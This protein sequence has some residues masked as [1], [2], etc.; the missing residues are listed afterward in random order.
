MPGIYDVCDS[1]AFQGCGDEVGWLQYLFGICKGMFVASKVP[2]IFRKWKTHFVF[3]VGFIF[4][5]HLYTKLAFNWELDLAPTGKRAGALNPFL[6]RNEAPRARRRIGCWF[7]TAVLIRLP[8]FPVWVTPFLPPF[9]HR[10]QVIWWLQAYLY[11]PIIFWLLRVTLKQL[12]E[13]VPRAECVC[14]SILG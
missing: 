10:S 11:S 9:V 5:A 12:W 2:R 6:K 7:L 13:F 14:L 4:F 3:G 8:I 1:Q